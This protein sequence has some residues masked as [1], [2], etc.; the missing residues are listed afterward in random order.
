MKTIDL[1]EEMICIWYVP[2]FF[3]KKSK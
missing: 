1:S 2:D 3:F